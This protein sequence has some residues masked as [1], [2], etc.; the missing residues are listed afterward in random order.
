MANQ[1]LENGLSTMA[2][3]RQNTMSFLEDIP[4]DKICF[5]VCPGS[6][7]CGRLASPRSSRS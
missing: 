6:R 2:F 5:Q 7:D 3:A 1:A 4:E